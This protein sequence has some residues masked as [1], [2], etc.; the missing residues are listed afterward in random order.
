MGLTSNVFPV[1]DNLTVATVAIE[2]DA[3]DDGREISCA[4]RVDGAESA[5]AGA[6]H[7]RYQ[8]DDEDER[9]KGDASPGVGSFSAARLSIRC[10]LRAA[11]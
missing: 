1:H 11:H 9:T 5:R 8:D 7:R 3:S 10:E 6:K 2:P 4:A